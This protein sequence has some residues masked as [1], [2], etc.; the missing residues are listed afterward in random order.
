MVSKNWWSLQSL[1]RLLSRVFS[2]PSNIRV[3]PAQNSPKAELNWLRATEEATVRKRRKEH[4][5]EKSV[6]T[7]QQRPGQLSAHGLYES[8]QWWYC[9]DHIL[10][11]GTLQAQTVFCL[12]DCLQ[13]R[14]WQVWRSLLPSG[15]LLNTA[16]FLT[17]PSVS[18]PHRNRG[19]NTHIRANQ[20]K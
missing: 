2:L 14:W 1:V 15:N 20:D 17:Y 11:G 7:M 8:S 12:L 16:P 10:Q 4:P 5:S 19:E 9:A 3:S 6:L 18:S 13:Q